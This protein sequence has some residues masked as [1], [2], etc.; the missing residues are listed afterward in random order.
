MVSICL[1]TVQ[2][3]STHFGKLILRKVI[4]IVAT[5]CQVLKLK[6]TKFDFG[7]GSVPDCT[8]ELTRFPGP[9]AGFKLACF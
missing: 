9:L 6:C 5:R 4:V 1:D 2:S 8:G 7:W 3:T